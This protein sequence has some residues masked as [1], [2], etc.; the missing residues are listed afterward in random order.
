MKKNR[1]LPV[2]LPL[3]FV[4]WGSPSLGGCSVCD[5]EFP[6]YGLFLQS[7]SKVRDPDSVETYGVQRERTPK[8]APPKLDLPDGLQEVGK[9]F[10]IGRREGCSLKIPRG[11]K[12][13]WDF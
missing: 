8:R 13:Q 5:L 3:V 7:Q 9:L 2:L 10:G 6:Q 1:L 11:F 12:C 4:W